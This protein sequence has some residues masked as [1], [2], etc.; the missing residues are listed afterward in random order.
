MEEVSSAYVG[1]ERGKEINNSLNRN[2][3]LV[4]GDFYLENY[5]G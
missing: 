3:R 1:K 2:P 5:L 4:S